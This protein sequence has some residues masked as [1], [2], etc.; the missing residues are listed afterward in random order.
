MT[1]EKFTKGG[2]AMRQDQEKIRYKSDAAIKQ[3]RTNI[4]VVLSYAFIIWLWQFTL[5]FQGEFYTFMNVAVFAMWFFG[6][7][8]L[9]LC[10]EDRETIIKHT[11]HQIIYYLV[12]TYIYDLFLRIVLNDVINTTMINGSASATLRAAESFLS[13]VSVMLKIGFPIAFIIW[14]LQKFSVYKSGLTKQ[15]QIELLRDFRKNVTPK[16]KN[17][18]QKEK[19]NLNNRY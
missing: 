6:T 10:K 12:I 8:G 13:V 15:Q 3:I 17:I 1:R 2:F 4:F 19:D 7:V 5:S 9:F 14:M 18:A 16:N 11:K